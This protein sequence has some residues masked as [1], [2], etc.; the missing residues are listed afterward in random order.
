MKQV[1]NDPA[2]VACCGLYCGACKAYLN[3]RCP[4]CRENSKAGWCTIRQCCIT[5]KYASCADC[6]SIR[7]V[8]DCGKFTNA[9]SRI[10]A[11]I[12]RSNRRACI[13]QICGKGLQRHAAIMAE[14][15]T[16]SLPR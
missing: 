10:F 6:A 16:H 14:R 5:N 11:F 12:F 1:A 4:G 13:E 3:E 15:K 2:L 9:V 8:N 7:D